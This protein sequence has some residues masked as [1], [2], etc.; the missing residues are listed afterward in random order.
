[1]HFFVSCCLIIFCFFFVLG[2]YIYFMFLLLFQELFKIFVNAW[3]N[4]SFYSNKIFG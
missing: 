3:T 2:R 1:M 4:C